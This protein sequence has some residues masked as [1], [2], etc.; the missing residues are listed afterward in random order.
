MFTT[1]SART[2]TLLV[3]VVV[4]LAI[5]CPTSAQWSSNAA[6]NLAIA[7]RSGAQV[8]SKILPTSDGGCYVSW[9]D[10]STG[11]YDVY[12]QRLDRNGNE[13]WTHNGVLIANRSFS[14]TQDYGLAV[15]AN[16]NA[17]ITYRDDRSTGT[18]IGVNKV[19][20]DGTLAWG[21]SGVLLTNTTAF[22]A[23]PKVAATS[24]GYYAV[25]WTQD[26][27]LGLQRLD[28][29]GTPQWQVG[30]VMVTPSTGSYGMSDMQPS[31]S[32]SFIVSMVA[33]NGFSSPKLLYSQRYDTEG[34]GVWNHGDPIAIFDSTSLQI[35]NFPT[36]L[37][38]GAGGAVYGWYETGGPEKSYVQHVDADG[39]ELFPHN[40]VAG[41]TQVGRFGFEPDYCYDQ[42]TGD[43]YLFWQETNT[44]QSERGLYGQRFVAGVRQWSDNGLEIRP[45][46]GES[47]S[48]I[49][50]VFAGGVPMVFCLDGTAGDHIVGYGLNAAG[51]LV[52]SGGSTT[53]CSANSDKLRVRGTANVCGDALLSWTDPRSDDGNIYGQNVH[54]DGTLGAATPVVAD[55]NC[56]GAVTADDI[57][58]FVLALLDADAYATAYPC[59][60]IAN[61]DV[62]NDQNSDGLDI[63]PFVQALLG[64]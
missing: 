49:T 53:V 15:D 50:A 57:A 26:A 59:C 30:G 29:D 56:D 64:S 35:G 55:M 63:G 24:D 12:L 14:S 62:N 60:D 38:D 21:A 22:V 41:S 32:G 48:F 43:I 36:F 27:S 17:I 20:P 40:G 25:G 61:A 33:Q 46:D 10:N 58:P 51:S 4:L 44:L 11:G 52:W 19:L 34:A 42:S 13:A 8:Q 5:T 6:V 9:Y 7:N 28:A 39:T 16:N 18:Q 37:S 31:L 45:L 1:Y 3:A 23:S 2:V 47:E 54:P